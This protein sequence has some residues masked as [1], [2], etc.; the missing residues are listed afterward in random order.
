ATHA[1]VSPSAHDFPMV[2]WALWQSDRAARLPPRGPV[3]DHLG[4][5][6]LNPEPGET[7]IGELGGSQQADRGDAQV[8]E[9]LR[10]QPDLAPLPRARDLRAGRARLG[11]GM[12][13]HTCRPV[14]QKDDDAATF[15][16]EAL[17]RGVDRISAAKHIADDV[18]AMQ[19]R[20]HVLAVTD[21]AVN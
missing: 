14:A 17:Q 12:R 11:D 16:L 1:S 8:L 10:A 20:Q 2:A 15:L 19:P 13:G 4:R 7:D 3:I 5:H 21:A 18:G 6:D 9:N